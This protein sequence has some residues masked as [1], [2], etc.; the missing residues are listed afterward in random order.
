MR[1]L[2]LNRTTSFIKLRRGTKRPLEEV[3]DLSF[4]VPI[5]N[6]KVILKSMRG[7]EFTEFTEKTF[8]KLLFN[9][10][11]ITYFVMYSQQ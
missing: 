10:F 6:G 2:S 11:L 4:L 5:L 9:V 1:L 3:I 7:V 8:S